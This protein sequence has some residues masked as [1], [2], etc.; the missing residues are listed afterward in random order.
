MAAPTNVALLTA[1]DEPFGAA[2]LLV[3]EAM[4]QLYGS[5]GV[6]RKRAK[7]QNLKERAT[8]AGS[9]SPPLP[10]YTRVGVLLQGPLMC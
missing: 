3:R 5:S 9:S 4:I 2:R 1:S 7:R 6:K 10:T 8:G